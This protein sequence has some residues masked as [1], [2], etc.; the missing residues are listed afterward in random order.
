MSK[1]SPE[2]QEYDVEGNGSEC[3]YCGEDLSTDLVE[4]NE[5]IVGHPCREKNAQ[6]EVLIKND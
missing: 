2:K 4:N 5:L 1:D 6:I 3:P